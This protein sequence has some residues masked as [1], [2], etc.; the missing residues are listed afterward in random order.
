M[1]MTDLVIVSCVSPMFDK[2]MVQLFITVANNAIKHCK[3][4]RD[5]QSEEQKGDKE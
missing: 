5:K 4:I 1:A 3:E 2:C